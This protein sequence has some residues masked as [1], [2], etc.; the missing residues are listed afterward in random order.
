V[1]L[2]ALLPPEGGCFCQFLAKG[3]LMGRKTF[4]MHLPYGAVVLKMSLF[5]FRKPLLKIDII[6]FLKTQILN[7]EGR[8][9]K[10]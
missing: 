10:A 4:G 7:H 1:G 9:F 5:A 6:P 8:A 3:F 2:L